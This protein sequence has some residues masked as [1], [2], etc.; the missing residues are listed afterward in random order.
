MSKLPDQVRFERE[1]EALLRRVHFEDGFDHPAEAELEG[2]LDF[3]HGPRWIVEL[4][5]KFHPGNYALASALLRC[6]GRLD[7]HRVRLWGHHLAWMALGDE[8][9]H[10]RDAAVCALERWRDEKS[11]S[12][13][14]QWGSREPVPWLRDYI[15]MVILGVEETKPK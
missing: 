13:L 9:L 7:V 11:I 10:I 5:E 1:V 4:W 14:K 3:P 12:Y 8:S 6:I 15:R 2:V